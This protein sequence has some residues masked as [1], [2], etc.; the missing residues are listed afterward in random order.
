[1][2]LS[3]KFLTAMLLC[4]SLP[5]NAD[6][7]HVV[8]G[9]NHA[10]PYRIINETGASGFYVDIFNEIA[11]RAG[12]L[13]SYRE[14]PFRR[15][16]L[17]V[18]QNEIDVMLGPLP[19]AERRDYMDF[20]IE[21]FPPE[22]RIFL[23]LNERNR[24]RQYEDLA[25]KRIG[26]LRGSTY[27]H[28][29]DEDTTLNKVEATSYDNLLSMLEYGRID[30]V[31]APEMVGIYTAQ[32][33]KIPVKVAPF[34]VPGETSYIGIALGSPLMAQRDLIQH[35]LKQIKKE[36]LYEALLLK[37]QGSHAGP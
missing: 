8:V 15:V 30:L 11:A 36:N 35:Y 20:S 24:I 25:N 31:I 6:S 4:L 14:A 21:A 22:R 7:L 12:W 16:L 1:M 37:Y 13:V 33:N 26:V 19:T 5:I 9:I 34:F 10:P 3:R 2:P 18:E 17:M 28:T 32:R 23:Y 27:F 29:F